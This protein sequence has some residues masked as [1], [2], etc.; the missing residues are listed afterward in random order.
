MRKQERDRGRL[1]VPH[2]EYDQEGSR[3]EG[4]R[5]QV[6]R[7]PEAACPQFNGAVSRVGV[8]AS[9]E[10]EKGLTR[11]FLLKN[12]NETGHSNSKP[13][14]RVQVLVVRPTSAPESRKHRL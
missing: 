3:R 14:T 11:V 7:A 13:A 1:V 12:R 8:S 10:V 5:A 6:T 9:V 4:G 2:G